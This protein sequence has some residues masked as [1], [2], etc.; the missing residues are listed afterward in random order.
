MREDSMRA[1]AKKRICHDRKEKIYDSLSSRYKSAN[2]FLKK[3]RANITI[4][5]KEQVEAD[6]KERE[7]RILSAIATLTQEIRI[8]EASV[9]VAPPECWVKRY[10]AQGTK[11]RYW[12]YK[13][14]AENAI[15]PSRVK[16]GSYSKYRHLGKAGSE[17]HVAAAIEIAQR[18]KIEA[19][20]RA[21]DSL[22]SSLSDVYPDER[23]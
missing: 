4:K 21:I 19:S 3:K 17:S 6:K 14:H 1:E 16:K 13:L 5:N 15:F 9:S 23:K 2:L 11:G 12:Y 22:L 8:L 20:L 18:G 10:Q 7:A